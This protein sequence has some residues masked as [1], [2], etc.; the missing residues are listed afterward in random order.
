MLLFPVPRI[1]EITLSSNSDEWGPLVTAVSISSGVQALPSETVHTTHAYCSNKFAAGCR[2]APHL[3]NTSAR[4]FPLMNPF[5]LVN[6]HVTAI[7]RQPTPFLTCFSTNVAERC[8]ILVLDVQLKPTRTTRIFS[9][10]GALSRVH[11]RLV[12]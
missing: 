9:L 10:V 7:S 2:L 1:I 8:L 11:V 6:P 3:V 4:D 5:G 12:S